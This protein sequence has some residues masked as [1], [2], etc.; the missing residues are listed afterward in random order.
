MKAFYNGLF[1]IKEVE[2]ITKE[3][4]IEYGC[5]CTSFSYKYLIKFKSGRMK[6]VKSEKIIFV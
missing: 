2:I 5:I 1:G 3:K 4:Y 6:L